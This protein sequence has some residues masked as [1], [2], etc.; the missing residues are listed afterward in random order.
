[1]KQ[2]VL[3]T[4]EVCHTDYADREKAMECEENHKLLEKATIIG[5]YNPI[6]VDRSGAPKKIRVKFPGSDNWF[7]YRR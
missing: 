3:Y 2:K 1:M 6:G 5:E 7:D 4:C